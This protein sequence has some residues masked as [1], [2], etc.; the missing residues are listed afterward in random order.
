MSTV[1]ENV[2]AEAEADIS[3][4]SN[5]GKSNFSV[6]SGGGACVVCRG[7]GNEMFAGKMPVVEVATVGAI[8]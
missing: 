2:D 8:M 6:G 1:M 5:T 4:C 3:R 7:R